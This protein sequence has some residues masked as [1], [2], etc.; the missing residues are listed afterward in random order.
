VLDA[1]QPHAVGAEGQADDQRG[2]EVFEVLGQ[3]RVSISP[4]FTS[5][6]ACSRLDT[7]LC[8]RHAP[9]PPNLPW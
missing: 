4:L 3:S 1:G 9:A 8:G 7:G 5:R 2:E 6:L